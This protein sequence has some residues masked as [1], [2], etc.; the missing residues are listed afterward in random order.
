MNGLLSDSP[1]Q[2]LRAVRCATVSGRYLSEMRHHFGGKQLHAAH[3]LRMGDQTTL[4]EPGDEPA[5]VEVLL[6][7]MQPID[8]GFRRVEYPHHLAC[9]LPGH[10]A[11]ALVALRRCLHSGLQARSVAGSRALQPAHDAR[12]HL[13][14]YLRPGIGDIRRQ[15]NRDVLS[16]VV[17]MS[18]GRARFAIN[19]QILLDLRKRIDLRRGKDRNT[20]LSHQLE[21]LGAIGGDTDRRMRSLDRLGH[22]G[23]VLNVEELSMVGQ[24]LA[25]PGLEYYLEPLEEAIAILRLGNSEAAE[26]LRQ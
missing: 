13:L 9:A 20:H 3:H 5:R 15:E 24:P 2:P 19:G 26:V 11:N 21:R 17:R 6:E 14:P 22:D 8:T 7:L 16:A 1:W 12:L 4:I 18:G 10:A 25:A 23:Q